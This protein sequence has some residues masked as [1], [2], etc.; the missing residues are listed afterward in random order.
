MKPGR[1]AGVGHLPGTPGSGTV[2]LSADVA[3]AMARLAEA[4][5]PAAFERFHLAG[6]WDPDGGAM[7][8]AIRRAA[9]PAGPPTRGF[10]WSLLRLASPAVPLFREMAEMRYLWRKPMRMANDRL[11]AAIGAGAAHAAR[12]GGAG[13]ARRARLPAGRAGQRY[14]RSR[15]VASRQRNTTASER[16]APGEPSRPGP[17]PGQRPTAPSRRMP[18]CG[19]AALGG[20]C[21]SV[22]LHA[23]AQGRT[24][25]LQRPQ[26]ALRISCSREAV[27]WN[28]KAPSPSA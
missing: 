22:V 28:S 10:P 18:G 20:P 7:V 9:R 26:P 19:T 1:P 15:N 4:G 23:R 17:E 25:T 24:G 27:R 3:E 16:S 2:G 13:D 5:E 6:H 11:V 12:R 21:D 8:A 14:R